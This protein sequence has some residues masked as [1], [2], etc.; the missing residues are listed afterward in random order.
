MS[1]KQQKGQPKTDIPVDGT[2]QGTEKSEP[3]RVAFFPGCLIP[4]KYPQMELAVRR[5]LPKLGIELVDVDEFTCCPDPIYFKSTDKMEW[6]TMAA[7]N[8][9]LAEERG[10]DIFTICSGCTATLSETSHLLAE[11]EEL[12]TK[13]NTKLE[14][15]G[16]HYRGTVTVRHIVTLLRDEVGIDTVRESVERPLE[17]LSVAIHYGCHLLK[18]SPIMNVDDPDTPH[19]M[20]DLLNAIGAHPVRHQEWILCCGKAIHDEEIPEEMMS[21]VLSS[22]KET[23]ADCLCV[24]CPSCFGEFDLGQLK[25]S[26]KLDRDLK[27]PAVYYFQLLGI[28][29]GLS[30]QDVGLHR[31]RVKAERILELYSG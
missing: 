10:V 11:N 18:P 8:L 2:G 19:M 17:D 13:V 12:L 9:C 3:R 16:K 26:R 20:E 27:T 5:T 1:R 31:H 28:A 15:I 25:V 14:R 29:Q 24:I 22:V 21:T 30:A 23:A 7:R 6:L 4:V